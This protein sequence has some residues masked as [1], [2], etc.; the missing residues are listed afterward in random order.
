MIDVVHDLG[1]GQ[2]GCQAWVIERQVAFEGAEERL[3]HGIVPTVT[4]SALAAN[5]P[6]GFQRFL[7]F[8]A[9]RSLCANIN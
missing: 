7:V 2:F 3:C 1:A 8:I 9:G 5:N 4:P 6:I